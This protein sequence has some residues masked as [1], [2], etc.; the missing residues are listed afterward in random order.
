MD[1]CPPL[2]GV[3]ALFRLLS[4][5]EDINAIGYSCVEGG[6]L[7]VV[8]GG[9]G[10]LSWNRGYYSCRRNY[11]SF[12]DSNEHNTVPRNRERGIANTM[13]Q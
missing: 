7:L 2:F 11:L 10:D 3:S 4:F 6:L 9:G 1:L 13:L 8:Q 5:V 12:H